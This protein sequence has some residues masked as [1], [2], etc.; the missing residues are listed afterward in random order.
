MIR[1]RPV[2]KIG[3]DEYKRF[4]STCRIEETAEATELPVVGPRLARRA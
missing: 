3:I 4:L 1:E 2:D